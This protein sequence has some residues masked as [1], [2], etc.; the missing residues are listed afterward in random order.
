MDEDS[1]TEIPF[2]RPV[3]F[4]AGAASE[5]D[6]YDSKFAVLDDGSLYATA[7]HIEG[8]ITATKGYIGGFTLGDHYMYISRSGSTTGIYMGDLD[9]TKGWIYVKQSLVTPTD[10]NG[11]PY[12]STV[13]YY[14][15]APNSNDLYDSK[16]AVLND[17]SLY[18]SAA[19]ITGGMFNIN[20]RDDSNINECFSVN[21]NGCAGA[22]LWREADLSELYDYNESRY[23]YMQLLGLGLYFGYSSSFRGESTNVTNRLM[24]T[25]DKVQMVGDWNVI[26]SLTIGDVNLVDRLDSLEKRIA[27]L[28][29]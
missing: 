23:P 6:V 27:Q 11:N 1:G 17:G 16:F 15:G 25:G 5:Y 4:Y 8:E 26:G 29:K 9:G 28:E 21:D 19:Q 7:A 12:Y 10:S 14:A 13:R 18:T 20:T 22:M 2:F 3:R 24:Y